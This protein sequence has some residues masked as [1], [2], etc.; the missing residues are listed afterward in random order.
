MLH[1]SAVWIETDELPTLV[2][3]ELD[4]SKGETAE[5]SVVKGELDDD[6]TRLTIEPAHS[7]EL[8]DLL[9]VECCALSK[10]KKHP[11]AL[12]RVVVLERL[13]HRRIVLGCWVVQ[14]RA[15]TILGRLDLLEEGGIGEVVNVLACRVVEVQHRRVCSDVCVVVALWVEYRVHRITH[16]PPLIP[17]LLLNL[18]ASNQA[19]VPKEVPRLVGG[20]WVIIVPLVRKHVAQHPPHGLR[21]LPPEV[22]ILIALQQVRKDVTLRRHV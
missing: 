21:L 22:P 6:L 7:A 13:A 20:D 14:Q 1:C 10:V 19:V 15:V 2:K 5:V 12:D 16:A 9:Q 3:L 8:S 18:H 17:P 11:V 4:L